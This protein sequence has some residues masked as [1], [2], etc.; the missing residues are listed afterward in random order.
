MTPNLLSLLKNRRRGQ[1]ITFL[2]VFS[3][4]VIIGGITTSYVGLS[5]TEDR[6][7]VETYYNN[8]DRM[9]NDVEH[10]LASSVSQ[11]NQI[12]G[13]STD[14]SDTET[15]VK[16][17][18]ATQMQIYQNNASRRVQDYS[19]RNSGFVSGYRVTQTNTGSL[20]EDKS[21][22]GNWTVYSNADDSRQVVLLLEVNS[23]PAVTDNKKPSIKINT[24]DGV[25][26][27]EFYT[28]NGV[29]TI[30][31]VSGPTKCKVGVGA[32]AQIDFLRG[33]VDQSPCGNLGDN[34]WGNIEGVEIKNGSE[35]RG[36]YSVTYNDGDIGTGVNDRGNAGVTPGVVSD[37]VGHPV[38]YSVSIDV[39]IV[40]LD[41][42]MTRTINVAPGEQHTAPNN[43]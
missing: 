28:D 18:I 22:N 33:M 17:R 20:V 8:M 2:A 41:G 3:V 25:K 43:V 6:Q 24:A 14:I 7:G 29:L 40:W 1:L 11:A 39:E 19:I 35:M 16:E 15:R 27:Y 37:P 23:L 5:E 4:L 26:E 21:G 32:V 30:D 36:G 38:V 13:E 34:E 10:T 42:S 9:T 12:P 31:D